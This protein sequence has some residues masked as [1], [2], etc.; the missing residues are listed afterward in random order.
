MRREKRPISLASLEKKVKRKALFSKR[1]L[2]FYFALFSFVDY[3]AGENLM[4]VS[5][6]KKNCERILSVE[7][8]PTVLSE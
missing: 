7:Y 3:T 6:E 4:S 2:L 8:L 1:F 5:D